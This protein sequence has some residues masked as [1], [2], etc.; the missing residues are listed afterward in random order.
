MSGAISAWAVEGPEGWVLIESGP[1]SCWPRLESGLQSLGVDPMD[2]K[3]VLLTHI[4]L[5]HAGGAWRLA[6][7][8]VPIHV[9]EFGARHLVD[10]SRLVASATRIYGD[11]MSRLWGDIK[12][13]EDELVRGCGDGTIVEVAGMRFRSVETPG[14][15]AHHHAW[16]LE[17]SD[18]SVCFSGDAAAMLI[19]DS[20][21][22][23]IPMPPP[24]FDLG[25]WHTT[26]DRLEAGSWTRMCLTHGG[27][28]DSKSAIDHHLSRLRK[29]LDTQVEVIREIRKRETGQIHQQADYR[30]WLLETAEAAGIEESRFDQFVSTGLLGMNLM[31]VAR[32]LDLE[33]AQG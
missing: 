30:A 8:G 20:D 7:R 21:W 23:S 5:D 12:P 28:L 18:H 13:C 19:P 25:A 29:G 26:I 27:S 31:G 32:Y 33:A 11:D 6:E 15:A 17:A 24:E 22:I 2:L 16:S 3:S 10:P 9:H 1:E 4:H 14:H